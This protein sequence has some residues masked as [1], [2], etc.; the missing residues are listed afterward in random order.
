MAKSEPERFGARCPKCNA[1]IGVNLF[2]DG[3]GQGGISGLSLFGLTGGFDCAA[4]GAPLKVQFGTD[5]SGQCTQSGSA[6]RQ[7]DVERDDEQG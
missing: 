3:S 4:C 1:Y 2:R 6:L 7:P 5:P